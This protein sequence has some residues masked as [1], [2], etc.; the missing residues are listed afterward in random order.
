MTEK[1][2]VIFDC[3]NTLFQNVGENPYKTL[4]DN[5]GYSLD[6]YERFVKLVERHLMLEKH[7]TRKDLEQA[8]EAFYQEVG[9]D[10][11]KSDVRKTREILENAADNVVAYPETQEV[12]DYLDGKYQLGFISN[13][14]FRAFQGLKQE[15]DVEDTFDAIFVSYRE[16]V[17]KPEAGVFETVLTELGV[18]P[19]EAVMIGDSLPDDVQAAEE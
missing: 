11:A 10:Y 17:I 15:F 7:E 3:W 12:L 1:K 19:D 2:A 14:N 4:A 13:T 9:V 8:I 18:T 6:D 16:G 5:L